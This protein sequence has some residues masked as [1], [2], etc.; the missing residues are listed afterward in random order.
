MLMRLRENSGEGKRKEYL[1]YI[2][3]EKL[4]RE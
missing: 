2:R 3:D 4:I 1:Q